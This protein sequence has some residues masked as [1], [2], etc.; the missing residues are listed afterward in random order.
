MRHEA[1]WVPV[2]VL[3]QVRYWRNFDARDRRDHLRLFSTRS[4]LQMLLKGRAHF[5]QIETSIKST[6]GLRKARARQAED[7]AEARTCVL[8]FFR[9]SRLMKIWNISDIDEDGVSAGRKASQGYSTS[10]SRA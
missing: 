8:L 4:M 2:A 9:S 7:A 10:C 6:D 1:L 3:T 5:R